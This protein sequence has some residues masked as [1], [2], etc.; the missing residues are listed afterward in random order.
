LYDSVLDLSNLSKILLEINHQ[1][2]VKVNIPKWSAYTCHS[3][4]ML[5]CPTCLFIA[6]ESLVGKQ[7]TIFLD[8]IK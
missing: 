8:I 3:S 5:H 7:S 2:R 1:A 4:N 6:D